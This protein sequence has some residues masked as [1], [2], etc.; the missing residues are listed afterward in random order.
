MAPKKNNAPLSS[1]KY[2]QKSRKM[3]RPR[4]QQH[5]HQQQQQK[6]QSPKKS[7]KLL[8][9][10]IALLV[11]VAI[12]VALY[13]Y[14]YS[15]VPKTNEL[16]QKS[17]LD[18]YN[19]VVAQNPKTRA[20]TVT[21]N[22]E[23]K[24]YINVSYNEVTKQI[25]VEFADSPVS[26]NGV[27]MILS[28]VHG[29]I[30]YSTK[31]EHGR[32]SFIVTNM[33]NATFTY[34]PNYEGADCTLAPICAPEEYNTIKPLTHEQYHTLNMHDSA[35]GESELL[36]G[37]R[38]RSA[39]TDYNPKVL[40]HPRIRVHC[41]N[42]GTYNLERC[43]P[44]T[45]LNELLE[46]VPYDVCTIKSDGYKHNT[47]TSKESAPLANN[48]Y[49]ECSKG[50]SI[51]KT[52]QHDYIFVDSDCVGRTACSNRGNDRIAT[53]DSIIQ[54]RNGNVDKIKQCHYGV[55]HGRLE[56]L[57]PKNGGGECVETV[58]YNTS[59]NFNYATGKTVCENKVPRTIKCNDR[60]QDV[61]VPYA[62][63]NLYTFEF[64]KAPLQYYNETTNECTPVT[65]DNVRSLYKKDAVA[66][67]FELLGIHDTQHPIYLSLKYKCTGVA[68]VKG[69][70]DYFNTTSV[71]KRYLNP[72]NLDAAIT[73]ETPANH[74]IDHSSPCVTK[75]IPIPWDIHFTVANKGLSLY[76]N[77][78]LPMIYVVRAANYNMM[79]HYY[80]WPVYHPVL[81]KYL[82]TTMTYD[83]KSPTKK[84]TFNT[85]GSTKM[86]KHFTLQKPAEIQSRHS[87]DVKT[88]PEPLVFKPYKNFSF[89]Y[90][91]HLNKS[92]YYV[93]V[94]GGIQAF[95]PMLPNNEMATE[96]IQTLEAEEL[97]LTSLEIKTKPRFIPW[98]TVT[99]QKTL[100]ENVTLNANGVT[101]STKVDPP[102]YTLVQEKEIPKKDN[103]EAKKVFVYGD[104]KIETLTKAKK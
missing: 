60:R 72:N 4:P 36:F 30:D 22:E 26:E 28:N 77:N 32:P 100:Y 88:Q 57:K 53:N 74:I 31:D 47:Q 23:L 103:I 25:D 98:Q 44:N 27:P 8:I 63:G 5:Q 68:D 51:K 13:M 21:Y 33:E 3:Q 19:K 54:C 70:A 95:K 65:S 15:E 37:A 90:K 104:I 83:D 34:P 96:V 50:A 84:L 29:R 94:Y 2:N 102:G 79:E 76:P 62:W 7:N 24:K 1:S 85:Y 86:F 80:P 81:Q 78:A 56:C 43:P 10:C 40:I 46:C 64:S 14:W 18:L 41:L 9:I 97:S 55:D 92:L 69:V 52:C 66:Q 6:E 16:S 17:L 12:C 42:G 91:A 87:R 93:L 73:I 67:N 59:F 101:H 61:S 48:E 39:T 58:H 38:S 45:V 99:E 89:D 20:F 49:Y 75:T 71:E 82:M 35:L 11:I